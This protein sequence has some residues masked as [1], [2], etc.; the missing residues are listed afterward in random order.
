MADG[1]SPLNAGSVFADIPKIAYEG[2]QS[3]NPFAYRYYNKDQVVLG[4]RME[5]HL[6]MAVCYWHTFCW[7]GF[8]VFSIISRMDKRICA[9]SLSFSASSASSCFRICSR[10]VGWRC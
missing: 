5:D 2:P 1:Q 9:R 7:D 10:A 4:K 6:R 3:D 8:D